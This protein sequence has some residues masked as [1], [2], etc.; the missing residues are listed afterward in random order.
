MGKVADSGYIAKVEPTRFSD[1]LVIEVGRTGVEDEA[2]IFALTAGRSEV[3]LTESGIVKCQ[4]RMTEI[5][6]LEQNP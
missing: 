1:R 6:C 4:L 2:V 5:Q 3:P